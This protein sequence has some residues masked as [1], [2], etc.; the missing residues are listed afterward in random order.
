MKRRDAYCGGGEVMMRGWTGQDRLVEVDKYCLDRRNTS[1]ST[2]FSYYATS[3][4][5]IVTN[6]ND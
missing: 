5:I 1:S 4:E 3:S 2:G 6:D